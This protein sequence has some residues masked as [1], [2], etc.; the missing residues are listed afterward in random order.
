MEEKLID[1]KLYKKEKKEK[2]HLLRCNGCNLPIKK[3]GICPHCG[4]VN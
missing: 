1:L 2:V 4:I 3:I